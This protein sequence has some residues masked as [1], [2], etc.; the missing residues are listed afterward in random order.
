MQLPHV[1]SKLMDRQSVIG[2]NSLNQPSAIFI[3]ISHILF[4]WNPQI[5]ICVW[6]TLKLVSYIAFIK[7]VRKT[8]GKV[9]NFCGADSCWQWR[10]EPFSD[11]PLFNSC[12]KCH[13]DCQLCVH[14]AVNVSLTF[15]PLN[16]VKKHSFME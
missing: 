3:R 11:L 14:L 8:W 1:F 16:S 4:R 15:A 2:G 10:S 5:K 13:K 12:P 6:E 9:F 7:Y